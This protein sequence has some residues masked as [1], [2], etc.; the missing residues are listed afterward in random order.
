MA[1]PLA[2]SLARNGIRVMGIAPGVM[3][4]RIYSPVSKN[5]EKLKEDVVFPRRF[6]KP[7]EFAGLFLEIVRNP[8]LN[9]D[10]IRL[11]GAMRF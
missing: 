4:T 7:E 3:D 10:T 1:L 8:M 2:R 6:G 11:D 9:G 5:R